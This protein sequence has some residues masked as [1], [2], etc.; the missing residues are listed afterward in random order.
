[1][2]SLDES[3]GEDI[4]EALEKISK[5]IGRDFEWMI[6]GSCN[7][8]L[9][10]IDVIPNDIDIVAH[11]GKFEAIKKTFSEHI[12]RDIH[13]YEGT[14]GKYPRIIVEIEGVEVE[15]MGED[16]NGVYFKNISEGTLE[17]DIRGMRLKCLE[18]EKEAEVY[19]MLGQEK[20]VEQIDEFLRDK[21]A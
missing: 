15:I 19:E 3:M 8:F 20:R 16:D 13:I 14:L 6:I 11:E 18:L 4:L 17:L 9:Q 21:M 2:I 10:G 12:K 7:M 5:M 1:M